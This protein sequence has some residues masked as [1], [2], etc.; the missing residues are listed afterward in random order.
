MSL[1]RAA[2][3]RR[4]LR[5]LKHPVAFLRSSLHVLRYRRSRARCTFRS[6]AMTG[7]GGRFLSAQ[8]TFPSSPEEL[9]KADV[10]N[11]WWYYDAELLPGISTEGDLPQPV[12]DAAAHHAS[13]VRSGRQVIPRGRGWR[14]SFLS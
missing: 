14:V 10:F 4:V 13:Q 6:T 3:I 11:D 8:R 12:A 7:R 2:M 5:R 9:K 1:D